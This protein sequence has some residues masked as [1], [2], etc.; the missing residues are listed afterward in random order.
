MGLSE[1]S[2]KLSPDGRAWT[3]TAHW[4]LYDPSRVDG[5][6]FYVGEQELGH[7]HL[8]GR[9]HLATSPDLGAALVAERLARPFRYGRGWVCEYVGNIGPDATVA[10]F[11]RNYE[12]LLPLAGGQ[13][14]MS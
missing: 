13:S 8:D 11:H 12:R 7:I 1:R 6:D 4:D 2:Q 14:L 3:A 9:L 10:L 5:I